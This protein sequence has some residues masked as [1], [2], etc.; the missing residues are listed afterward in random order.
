MKVFL[1]H[2]T[3]VY[4]EGWHTPIVL[5]LKRLWLAYGL[6]ERRVRAQ[7]RLRARHL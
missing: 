2:G 3:G 5:E 1:L 4:P 6:S 7:V